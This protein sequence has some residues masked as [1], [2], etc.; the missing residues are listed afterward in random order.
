MEKLLSD[1]LITQI[2]QLFVKLDHPVQLFLFVSKDKQEACEPTQQ[3]L[4]ELVPLSE[5]LSLSIHDIDVEYDLAQHY[6]VQGKAPAIV[7]AARD[8]EQITDYGIRYLGVPAGHEFST[9][10]QDLLLVSGRDSGLTQQLRTYIKSLTKPLHLEV[11]VT[12]T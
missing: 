8:G 2:R 5:M 3:L 12:P 1:D 11:F 6:K 7:I 9:L 10:I 4:E